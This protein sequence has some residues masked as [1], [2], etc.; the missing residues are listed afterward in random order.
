MDPVGGDT[1][2]QFV[3][4]LTSELNWNKSKQYISDNGI[5][6]L[7][8]QFG[9]DT[10]KYPIFGS[11]K[12]VGNYCLISIDSSIPEV[13]LIIEQLN[14]MI[15][16]VTDHAVKSM[17]G[18][19]NTANLL[20]S[21]FYSSD[22]IFLAFIGSAVFGFLTLSLFAYKPFIG[23]MAYLMVFSLL[24]VLCVGAGLVNKV[25][26]DQMINSNELDSIN[27]FPII[28]SSPNMTSSE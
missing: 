19:G 27:C 9:S 25:Y 14:A 3:F 12:L 13:N 4:D 15:K 23:V 22:M 11:L 10:T 16:S 24:V 8:Y 20:S 17:M 7:T 26:W 28:S 6:G 5:N 21:V 18:K 1:S 2:R